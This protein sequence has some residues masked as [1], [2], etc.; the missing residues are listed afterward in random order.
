MP[1]IYAHSLADRPYTEW[2]TL[3]AHAEAVATTAHIFAD[4]FGWGGVARA[5]GL[6]HDIG[7]CSPAFQAYIR[8]GDK[9]AR[10]PDHSTAGAIEAVAAYPV[11]LG[12]ILAAIIARHHAGL[13][14]GVDLETRLAKDGLPSYEGWRQAVGTLPGASDLRPAQPQRRSEHRGFSEAFLIRMLF[15]C[16][17]DADRLETEAFYAHAEGRDPGRDGF[18]GLSTLRERLER[19]MAQREAGA[20]PTALNRLRARIRAHA[21]GKAALEPGLFTLTVPTGGGKTLASLSFALEHAV[22]H[23][24]GRVVYVIPFTSIIEQTADVFRQVLAA[25][26]G[27]RNEDDILEHHASFDWD[28]TR[29]RHED[30]RGL[31][32]ADRLR[33]AAE[34]WAAPVVVTTAVQFFESLF[35]NRTSRCRKLH[36]LARSV[37]VLDEAQTMPL[38]LLRPCMAA[39]DE[40][41]RNYGAT[42]VLCTATQPALRKQDG[43]ASGLDIPA[44]RELAPD[45]DDLYDRLRRV[46]VERLPEPVPDETIAARFAEQPQMLCIV[47]R[48]APA[49]ALYGLIR[50]LPGAVHLS[51]LM[52]PAHR[53][54]VLA[55]AR[56]RLKAGMPVRIVSTS[57]TGARIETATTRA[58]AASST[59]RPLTGARIETEMEP[60]GR[61]GDAR[62]P[63]TGARIETT[64]SCRA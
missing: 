17:I 52:C 57:L 61:N 32:A 3:Q 36:N 34:N 16:L 20:E 27:S 10:G 1:D 41:A 11:P 24:L 35:A 55:A 48:R 56:E 28:A 40:L 50:D 53:R 44:E 62:R 59:G 9:A 38:H 8:A 6:L 33:R 42:V 46:A 54:Q 23:G 58:W 64:V 37:I 7:K 39:L 26:S 5:A 12:R 21:V 30:G 60:C 31:D 19:V 13:A 15:S 22:R 43:F 45:P 18:T 25:G 4:R 29:D 49:Q 63:L 2:E 14:D 51:T 47:N